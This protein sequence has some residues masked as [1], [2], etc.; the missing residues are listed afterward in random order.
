MGSEVN[1]LTLFAG[2]GGADIGLS[3]AGFKH[4][5]CVEADKHACATLTAAEFPAVRAWIG[6]GPLRPADVPV[7]AHD[8]QPVGL[9][10]A[11][12]PCQPY[13][14]AG[15]QA[16]ADDGRDGWPATLAAI[17]EIR[18]R[19]VVVENVV[20]APVEAWT[21]ALRPLYPWV[22]AWRA[23]AVDWG[24]PSHRDRWYL[25]A[26]PRAVEWPRPTHYG[27]KVPWLLR[28][29]KRPWVSF[30]DALG[31]VAAVLSP[32]NGGN[33]PMPRT[34]EQPAHTVA[35]CVRHYLEAPSPC[36]SATEQK[37]H[38]NP[39][40]DRGRASPI[41]R[42][43]DAL[44]LGTG[45]RA[46]TP[47]ECAVLCGFPDGYPFQGP[48]YAHYRQIGNCVAP[49]MAEVLGRAIMEADHE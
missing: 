41:Q 46:L 27:P 33:I 34:P 29:G 21:D 17:R 40:L 31:L 47:A 35:S 24:L 38:T 49:V 7:W 36:V 12:P 32:G 44:F 6:D 42:A 2:A 39:H 18:P 8:G 28:A 45:R 3:R 5:A 13:S 19:W 20:G 11:S 9:L 43:S 48:K 16:G 10:W 30:G 14:R 22:G 4:L 37:G 1:V 25:V 26:G 15:S 23:D